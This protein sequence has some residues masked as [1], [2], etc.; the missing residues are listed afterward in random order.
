MN[1][2]ILQYAMNNIATITTDEKF[3]IGDNCI[4]IEFKDGRNLKISEDEVRYQA[5]EYLQSEISYIKNKF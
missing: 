3:Y 2:K 5:T 4:Y 1:E